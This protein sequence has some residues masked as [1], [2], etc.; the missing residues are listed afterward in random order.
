MLSFTPWH[1]HTLIFFEP[2]S[3]IISVLQNKFNLPDHCPENALQTQ[4]S[5]VCRNPVLDAAAHKAH[6]TKPLFEGCS[7]RYEGL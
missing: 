5:V 4:R 2:H 1:I 7:D 3:C 6:V